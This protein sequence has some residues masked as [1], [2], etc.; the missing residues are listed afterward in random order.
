VTNPQEKPSHPRGHSAAPTKATYSIFTNNASTTLTLSL[1]LGSS[2]IAP[3]Q[4]QSS[5]TTSR[6][7]HS[8]LCAAINSTIDFPPISPIPL[9]QG[10]MTTVA[11]PYVTAS[12]AR[13]IT[14]EATQ[15]AHEKASK[16]ARYTLDLKEVCR[17]KD[18]SRIWKPT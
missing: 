14:C 16:A 7:H 3:P 10:T 12:E 6:L 11:G 18:V 13:R 4:C 15:L 17:Q 5:L 1:T 2:T 8:P 9:T